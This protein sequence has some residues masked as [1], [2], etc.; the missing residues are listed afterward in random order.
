MNVKISKEI[1]T[2]YAVDFETH[3]DSET[4]EAFKEGKKVDTGVWLWY[5]INES[6]NYLDD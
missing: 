5:L 6:H 1:Y 3:A 4:I 2:V